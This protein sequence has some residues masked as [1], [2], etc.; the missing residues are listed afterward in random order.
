MKISSINRACAR[1]QTAPLLRQAFSVAQLRADLP[2]LLGFQ[3]RLREFPE[4]S[5]WRIASMQLA[6]QRN[7]IPAD[8]ADIAAAMMVWFCS[9]KNR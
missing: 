9:N 6:L 1:K 2:V 4:I 5:E 8:S 3:V 7:E